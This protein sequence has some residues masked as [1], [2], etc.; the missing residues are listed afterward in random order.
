[1]NQPLP[2]KKELQPGAALLARPLLPLVRLLLM[3]YLTGPF[4]RIDEVLAQL[5]EPLETAGI[6]YPEPDRLL[7]PHRDILLNFEKLKTPAATPTP[8]V[9]DEARQPLALLEAL[10]YLVCHAVLN[11]ELEVINSLLC[12]PCRCTL[13]CTGPDP[14]MAQEFF[15]IPLTP[16]EISLFDLPLIDTSPSRS[17]DSTAEPPL[18]H[19]GREFY[20]TGPALYHWRQ[21][22]SMILPQAGRCPR[23]D[24]RGGC[25]IYL[26]RPK[27]CRLPQIFSYLLEEQPPTTGAAAGEAAPVY[28][29]RHKLLAVWDCPYVQILQDEIGRF[30]ETSG[31][32]PVFRQNKG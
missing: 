32:E 7:A 22:W 5:H 3:L 17:T 19:Q 18:L 9:L 16:K 25:G 29:A 6:R 1:M 2:D 26:Q 13:C 24:H 14:G 30:A 20:R 12:A 10:E 27:V 31:L 11:R 28:L 4:S 23:L 15:E 21:G 8:T